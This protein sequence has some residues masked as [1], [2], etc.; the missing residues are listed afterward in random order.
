MARGNARPAFVAGSHAR[1]IA[2]RAN[3]AATIPWPGQNESISAT[4]PLLP[5]TFHQLKIFSFHDG[6]F[7]LPIIAIFGGEI[8]GGIV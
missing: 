2:M 7:A 8:A 1:F 5:V 4:Q 6:G 3:E